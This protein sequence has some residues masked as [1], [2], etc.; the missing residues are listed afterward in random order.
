MRSDLQ[1]ADP[2]ARGRP[3]PGWRPTRTA[4]CGSRPPPGAVAS[5]RPVKKRTKGTLP[6]RTPSA[7]SAGP[8]RAPGNHGPLARGQGQ[9]TGG[10]TAATPFFRVVKSDRIVERAHGTIALTKTEMPLT[11]AVTPARAEPDPRR[12]AR[13]RA[14]SMYERADH[15]ASGSAEGSS[16]RWRAAAHGGHDLVRSSGSSSRTSVPA[17]TRRPVAGPDLRAQRG[18][19]PRR[20]WSADCRSRPRRRRSRSRAPASSGT[21]RLSSIPCARTRAQS[22]NVARSAA[23]ASLDRGDSGRAEAIV[24][25]APTPM[26]RPSGSLPAEPL[27]DAQSRG[28]QRQCMAG[29]R[30]ESRVGCVAQRGQAAGRPARRPAAHRPH[31]GG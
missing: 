1:P 17:A 11:S 20:R 5:A 7:T 18:S 6:P 24:R 22:L 26:K 29:C 31:R 4:S 19:T 15:G 28:R 25:A 2:F 14:S 30:A 9:S 10:A 16:D 27:D 21:C 12:D 3:P 8:R 23:T 13:D